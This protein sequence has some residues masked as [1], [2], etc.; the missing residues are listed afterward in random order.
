MFKKLLVLS[1]AALSLYGCGGGGGG[2]GG[3]TTTSGPTADEIAQSIHH[4]DLSG[5]QA[6]MLTGSSNSTLTAAV[7]TTDGA[8]E[9]N[10]LYKVTSSGTLVR[11]GIMDEMNV[12]LPRG[13]I[14]PSV[15]KELTAD[16]V[17]MG[18]SIE[19]Q[20]DPSIGGSTFTTKY[21]L[22]HKKT[23]LAY[24]ATAVIAQTN[25][26]NSGSTP[27]Y[28]ETDD[29]NNIYIN[30]SGIGYFENYFKIDTSTLGTSS[31]SAQLIQNI[32]RIV[33]GEIDSSGEYMLYRGR[34]ID[35][36]TVHRYL[37]LN[38]DAIANISLPNAGSI[39]GIYKGLNGRV[40]LS[41]NEADGVYVYT[42]ELDNNSNLILN[43]IGLWSVNRTSSG[44]GVELGSSSA[45]GRSYSGHANTRK[46]I[47]GGQIVYFFSGGFYAA[48]TVDPEAGRVIYHD[49]V[50]DLFIGTP[51][52]QVSSN[53]IFLYGTEA[54]SGL[55]VIMR[56]DP[57]T[58]DTVVF[59]VD[60]TLDMNSYQVLST[61]K[62]R[63]EAIKLSDQSTVIGEIDSNGNVTITDTIAATDPEI[64]ILEA[65]SPADFI[66]IDG[67]YQDWSTDL[68]IVT[69]AASDA[70]AGHDLTYYSQ[71]ANSSKYYG[72]V[73]FNNDAIT[74]SSSAVI[75]S[76]DGKYEVRI[77]GA[78]GTFK[79]V[80]NNTTVDLRSTGATYAIGKAVEFSIPLS[81]LTGAAQVN[82]DVTKV[83]IEPFGDVASV[84]SIFADPDYSL[85]ITMNTP[86]GDAEV[87]LALTGNYTL[88]FTKNTVVINDGSSDTD[89]A[90]NGGSI[91]YPA[92]D[93]GNIT[94]VIPKGLIGTPAGNISPT[95]Q[96]TPQL[97]DVN[98]DTML[99]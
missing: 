34:S 75:I 73:E 89:L 30:S 65:I 40:Y 74:T 16:Y 94:V 1:L 39:V 12:E 26:T 20:A 83:T 35:D 31:L 58:L 84:S 43:K 9:P 93:G 96:S 62:V 52:Y 66:Y 19:T 17:V 7:T 95:E 18:F 81:V 44:I 37:N 54:A 77:E 11:V 59:S 27:P 67:D 99:M 42:T 98:Q 90:G 48:A 85:D 28:I 23:G 2:G 33:R 55:D 24:N 87:T 91:T 69:D 45:P 80:V 78:S 25:M 36:S 38:S 79:D 41:V 92:T 29:Q 21:F 10:S 82:I 72:L 71:T 88:R 61:D 56:Y 8:L 97:L 68:R 49:A 5:A 64:L 47:V 86:L 13:T 4:L 50:R 53:Y 60:S 14:T 63:F 70:T 3:S 32:D 76:I 57:V 22:V 46:E 51:S 15:V 6:L